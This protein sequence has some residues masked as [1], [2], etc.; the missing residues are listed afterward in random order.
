MLSKKAGMNSVMVEGGAMVIHSFL[1]AGPV[2]WVVLT[3][4]PIWLG[5]LRAIVQELAAPF[6]ELADLGM[7]A[8]G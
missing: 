1:K 6:P 2:D 3:V 7:C 5:G 4:A 8:T